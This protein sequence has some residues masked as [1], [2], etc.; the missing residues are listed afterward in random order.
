MTKQPLCPSPETPSELAR[1]AMSR[2][3]A[4]DNSAFSKL[5]DVLAPKLYGYLLR[6]TR[7]PARSEDLLQQTMLQLH[8]VRARF[9]PEAPVTPWAFAIARRILIDNHR[10]VRREAVRDEIHSSEEPVTSDATDEV[11]HTKRVARIIEQE[12]ARLPEAQ[13]TAFELMQRDGLTLREVATALGTTENAIKLRAHRAR[14][15]LR[16]AI[17]LSDDG[18]DSVAAGF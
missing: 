14:T 12:L 4:G 18:V 10:G 17:D 13:R 6:Q 16:A 3:A 1:V 8:C 2:Y 7:D 9:Q 11:L 15:A 5:Y